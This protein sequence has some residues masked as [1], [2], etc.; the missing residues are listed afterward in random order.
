MNYL[1]YPIRI[2]KYIAE[3]GWASRREA[4]VLI[5]NGKILV[6]G[7]SATI[8]QQITESDTVELVG[9]TKDKVYLA[10]YK[11]RGIITH[12]PD[13]ERDEVDIAMRLEKDYGLTEVYPVGRLDK[14]S[15]GLM[16]LTNDG[17]VTGPL[18]D[19]DAGHEKE[20]VV[21]VDKPITTQFL[22]QMARGVNIEGYTTKPATVEQ[23][24]RTQNGKG[25]RIILTE[26]KK[27]QIRRMCAAL[28]Y[29]VQS[30]TRV[31][32]ENIELGKLK[33]NQYR[34]LTKKEREVFLNTLG[35]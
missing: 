13:T 8:G 23:V 32:I 9:N 29:Q 20:Y 5:E 10:Y 33:P 28:G 12:S 1:K 6:N 21:H 3:Q 14:D 24:G 22:K 25:F 4:D 7:K 17:R 15:E 27:H 19:P 31:R 30:S 16:L 34:K 26:G 18:L 35:V 2:N 11:G